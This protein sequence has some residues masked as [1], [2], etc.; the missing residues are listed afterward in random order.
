MTVTRIVMPRRDDGRPIPNPVRYICD[1]GH[2]HPS[3]RHAVRCNQ[4][5]RPK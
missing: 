3:R 4:R 2:T 5:N 1:Q